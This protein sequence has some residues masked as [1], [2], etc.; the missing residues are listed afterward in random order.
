LINKTISDYN[1]IA[2]KFS[3]TRRYISKDLF[4]IASIINK[5]QSVLDYGCGNGRMAVFFKPEKYFGVDP[6]KALISIAKTEFPQY[7][8][9]VIKPCHVGNK[10]N[11]ENILCLS[12]IHHLP[13]NTMQS[14]LI[15]NFAKIMPNN[16][17]L[18]VTA[19]HVEKFTNEKI[20]KIPFK[21]GDEKIT[22]QIYSFSLKE[23]E[24]IITSN[25][26][27]IISSTIKPRNSGKYS[28]IEI[29]AKK[30]I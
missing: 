24:N 30:T 17:K 3:S 4:Q 27:S 22:R 23:L 13:N 19:W 12:M 16:G 11:F 1:L 28:N 8:Y 20:A 10:W 7:R 5:N 26:F 6:S 21:Y 9:S 18:I 14:Q 25:G 15:K 29:F 2:D